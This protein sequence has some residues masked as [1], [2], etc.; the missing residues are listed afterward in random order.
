MTDEPLVLDLLF[1]VSWVEPLFF[2]CRLALGSLST[3][4]LGVSNFKPTDSSAISLGSDFKIFEYNGD[5][6]I[7]NGDPILFNVLVKLE[8]GMGIGPGL[9]E[10]S[11]D[12]F[13]VTM[14]DDLV[15]FRNGVFEPLLL[16]LFTLLA[17]A[18]LV[19]LLVVAVVAV[20]LFKLF[21]LV[22]EILFGFG[23]DN[24]LLKGDNGLNRLLLVPGVNKG[25]NGTCLFAASGVNVLGMTLLVVVVAAVLAASFVLFEKTLFNGELLKSAGYVNRCLNILGEDLPLFAIDV[26]LIASKLSSLSSN[27]KGSALVG[28]FGFNGVGLII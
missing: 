9:L 10:P 11:L 22:F 27:V 12:I 19:L 4:S 26:R 17:F 15:L 24:K 1:L 3:F 13:N 16:M 5:I 21:I 8:F 6:D 28:L 23:L 2:F 7:G 20:V 14:F 18:V 25:L